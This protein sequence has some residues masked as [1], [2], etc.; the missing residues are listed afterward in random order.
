MPADRGEY[1]SVPRVL[2]DGKDYQALDPEP[3]HLFLVLKITMGPAGIEV[4]YPDA[5]AIELAE[6][7]GYDVEEVKRCRTALVEAGW[8]RMERN[9]IWIV[10]QLRYE[11]SLSE[12]NPKHR[13]SVLTHV[14]GLPKL[15]IVGDFIA[16]YQAWIEGWEALRKGYPRPQDTHSIPILE[17]QESQKTEDRRQKQ[18]TEVGSDAPPPP[19]DDV[20][21]EQWNR[22]W[23]AVPT[24]YRPA[25]VGF[26]RAARNPA[27]V[28]AEVE[29]A[30]TGL[31]P[32]GYSW[33]VVGKALHDLAVAGAELTSF[34]LASFCRGA[35]TQPPT[36]TAPADD[37]GE[38]ARAGRELMR[39]RELAERSQP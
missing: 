29:A 6:Q 10:D 25:L 39:E 15:A 21:S 22:I 35:I 20:P 13:K 5:H 8:V 31:T 9:V 36:D 30:H 37:E 38:F 28:V 32:P 3:R 16:H 14:Q 27:A 1:R 33:D 4:H 11:P 7:T 18:K 12:K 26:V 19:P 24:P 34:R 23:S 17:S 2:V